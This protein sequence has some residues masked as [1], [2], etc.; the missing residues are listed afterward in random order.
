MYLSQITI[1]DLGV[2][3]FQNARM[4]GIDDEVVVIGG[5]QRAGKTTFLEAIRRLGY[6]IERNP[7]LPP[8]VDEYSLQ[9]TINHD[10]HEYV[11]KL[12]GHSDPSLIGTGGAQ[13]L[14]LDVLYGGVSKTQYQQLFTITLD[15]LERIPDSIDTP[16]DLAEVLLGAAYG[17]VAL[18]P[19]V[20]QTV[21][22]RAREIGRSYGKP[23]KNSE[24][25]GPIRTIEDGIERRDAANRQVDEWGERRETLAE[26]TDEIAELETEVSGLEAEAERLAVLDDEYATLLEF[27]KRREEL[28]DADLEAAET[29]PE[30]AVGRADRVRQE[31]R[32]LLEEYEQQRDTLQ[33]NAPDGAGGAYKTALLEHRSDLNRFDRQIAKWETQVEDITEE[34]ARLDERRDE[35]Q[36]RV[37]EIRAEWD[38]RF[39]A[40]LAVRTDSLADGDISAAV[41]SFRSA[42]SDLEAARKEKQ[43]AEARK[44]ELEAKLE[45]EP[46]GTEESGIDRS[47][48]GGAVAVGLGA[49]ALGVG[50]GIAGAPIIG[51]LAGVVALLTGLYVVV[52]RTADTEG[53]VSTARE[54]KSGIQT[55][56]ADIQSAETTVS[57]ARERRAEAADVLDTVAD[58]LGLPDD[59][60]PESV[61]GFYTD[62]AACKADI[63]EFQADESQLERDRA[64]LVAE[65]T[66]AST[67][68][69]EVRPHHWEETAPIERAEHLIQAVET[70][71]EDLELAGDLRDTERALERLEDDIES[72]INDWPAVDDID[73]EGRSTSDVSSRLE[74]FQAAAEQ[75]ADTMD[76]K[77]DLEDQRE[78][79]EDKLRTGS[80]EAAFEEIKASDESWLD[81][82]ED[83][84][85][86][87]PDA[88][89]VTQAHAAVEEHLEE[90]NVD[91]EEAKEKRI[92]LRNELD[93]LKSDDDIV[94]A[95]ERI[96]E[97]REELRT[98]GEE[99]AVN[100]I[101]EHLT[102]RLHRRFI[103]EVAGPLIDDA[104]EIFR[105]I[106]REYEGITHNEQFDALDFDAIRDGKPAQSS[107]ELSRATAEQ[108]FLAV[109]LARIRQLDVSLPVVI[110]DSLTNFDPAHGSRTF[111]T[112]AELATTNQVFFLTCHPEH[113]ALAETYGN[114]TQFWG[115]DDGR[116]TGPFESSDTLYDLLETESGHSLE[117][118]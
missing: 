9:A 27:Q 73:T 57:E 6:G 82:F 43:Q 83:L 65:L 67:T 30:D 62:V 48:L 107:D 109:R 92:E 47:L 25:N 104:S 49:L 31:Y 44:A 101:A 100:R 72:L 26:T 33:G 21:A 1:R 98:L 37:S 12:E 84:A 115:L 40:V 55:A 70:A 4:D 106:T 91:L 71:A 59:V 58:T 19:D 53:T 110:D 88:A 117:L 77:E 63:R 94:E 112:I 45:E 102:G 39:D 56:E 61:H 99:Y 35:L 69:S 17:D 34:T 13:P 89:S 46:D 76:T 14:D 103:E 54:L 97:G 18:I 90:L 118:T 11:L 87:Y 95:R 8:A 2:D 79:I 116:F 42:D 50:G 64:D 10:G 23:T 75:A 16:E 29:L 15:E 41:E 108:L 3:L 85:A 111:R 93:E 81:V 114:A 86:D 74:E 113:V 105:S 20:E 5:P 36:R 38:G 7:D 24:L 51:G 68:V 60:P 96:S 66:A 22:D 28:E 32:G 78:R 80:T 52:S